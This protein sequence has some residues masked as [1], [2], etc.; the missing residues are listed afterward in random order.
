MYMAGGG[1]WSQAGLFFFFLLLCRIPAPSAER[2]HT[3]AWPASTY[4]HLRESPDQSPNKLFLKDKIFCCYCCHPRP[5]GT[6]AFCP[7]GFLFLGPFGI[8]AFCQ[9]GLLTTWPNVTGP[10]V[11]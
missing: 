11:N 5:I 6:L 3:V 10:S 9:L 7:L 2:Q 1:G 8:I 4:G